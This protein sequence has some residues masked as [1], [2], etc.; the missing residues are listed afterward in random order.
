MD[1]DNCMVN[2]A[3]F[4]MEFICDESCGKCSPCR[5]GTKRILEY[6]TKICD[7]KATMQDLTELE[8]LAATIKVGSLCALGQTAAN[9]V[10]STLANFR[11]EYIAH[12]VDKKCPAKVCKNLMKYDI[13]KEKCIGC[14]LCERQCPVGAITKTDYIAP[15][16]KLPSRVIDSDKCVKCGL[17]AA[18]CKFKAI[19]KK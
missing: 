11:D 8:E 6:L 14:G 4:Y 7:G 13:D 1:E 19:E 10:L 5:I 3:K 2:I 15:G 17:C 9:P 12:I 16:H 18:N